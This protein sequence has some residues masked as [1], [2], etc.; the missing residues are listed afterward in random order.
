[1]DELN[2][3]EIRKI[4]EETLVD[5]L[6]GFLAS[7]RYTFQKHLQIFNG[8]NVMVGTGVGT[9]IGTEITQKLSVYGVAPVVQASAITP[10]AG[11]GTVDTQAR[12]AITDI[13]TAIKNF[14]IIA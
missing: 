2:K 13:L 10:P 12:N 1:M 3:Q 5:L 6:P 8:R 14:G 9:S 7:D 4:V 11:G